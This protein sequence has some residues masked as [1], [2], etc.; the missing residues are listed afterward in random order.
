ML[1]VPGNK[2]HLFSLP[3]LP[4][5]RKRNSSLKMDSFVLSRPGAMGGVEGGGGGGGLRPTHPQKFYSVFRS[6]ELVIQSTDKNIFDNIVC[7]CSCNFSVITRPFEKQHFIFFL[8][9]K[10]F[11]VTFHDESLKVMHIRYLSRLKA[12]YIL[13]GKNLIFISFNK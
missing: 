3:T 13:S 10:F 5:L 2:V 7:N 9:Y 11:E 8:K 12:V 1:I 4:H 6:A